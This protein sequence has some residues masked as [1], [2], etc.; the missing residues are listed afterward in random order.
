MHNLK[1]FDCV[2]HLRHVPKPKVYNGSSISAPLLVQYDI[3]N[4]PWGSPEVITSSGSMFVAY[5]SNNNN[6][7]NYDS[8]DPSAGFN[9]SYVI[10]W[11]QIL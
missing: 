4:R 3:F 9:A 5:S 6:N 1:E 7:G 10:T 2:L 8:F 11:R